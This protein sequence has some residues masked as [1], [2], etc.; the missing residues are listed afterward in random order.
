M[1]LEQTDI[2]QIQSIINNQISSALTD[3]LKESVAPM[4]SGATKRAL[5]EAPQ[6]TE[7][8]LKDQLESFK[9]SIAANYA[10][11]SELVNNAVSMVME[12]LASMPDDDDKPSKASQPIDVEYLTQEIKQDLMRQFE[13]TKLNPL[14]QK[15]TAYERELEQERQA[16]T[17]AEKATMIANRNQRFIDQLIKSGQVDPAAAE[18]ALDTAIKKGYIKESED[19]SSFVVEEMDRF[20]IEKVLLPATDKLDDILQK[21]ELQYFRP[22]RSGT[23]TGATP[24][25]RTS[26]GAGPN[27]Q[28]LPTTN[29]E[30]VSAE[31][32][33]R[34]YE[35]GNG[36]KVLGDLRALE[37]AS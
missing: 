37:Q 1:P 25:M 5:S 10:D 14:T 19:G 9:A 11:P 13:E 7:A 32:L 2:E 24:G 31:E 20:G 6:L 22:A 29:P 12:Q 8:Q 21:P 28:I 33:L 36:E 3:F 30:E 17:A 34:A 23:G 18:L 15:L 4:V 35:S 27:L 16:R 26:T